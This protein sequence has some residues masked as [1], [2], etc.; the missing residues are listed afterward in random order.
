MYIFYKLSILIWI[1]KNRIKFKVLNSCIIWLSLNL[2]RYIQF[3]SWHLSMPIFFNFII[4]HTAY[5]KTLKFHL[6][7][8]IITFWILKAIVILICILISKLVIFLWIIDIVLFEM[9]LIYIR[10]LRM[11]LIFGLHFVLILIL[12][13]SILS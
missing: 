13:F 8:Q 10:I 2:L 4:F 12:K 7:L 5:I 9:F 11:I 3:L 1:L 6:I